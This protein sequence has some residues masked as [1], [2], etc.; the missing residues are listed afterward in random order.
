MGQWGRDLG[1]KLYS[2]LFFQLKIAM[3]EEADRLS[4]FI[5]G[6]VAGV[7]AKI[8]GSLTKERLTQHEA[9]WH[10]MGLAFLSE[11]GAFLLGN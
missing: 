4:L 1:H 3:L 2:P 8:L 10:Q 5:Y 6:S 11:G 7:T 9:C